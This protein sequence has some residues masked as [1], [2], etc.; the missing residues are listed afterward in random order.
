ML[1]AFRTATV[2]TSCCADLPSDPN[3]PHLQSPAAGCR[4]SRHGVFE[5]SLPLR[6]LPWVLLWRRARIVTVGTGTKSLLNL[7]AKTG[8][9]STKPLTFTCWSKMPQMSTYFQQSSSEMV[10]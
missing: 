7:L 10:C 6:R 2:R 5:F 1:G 3:H 4:H 9:I 8:I